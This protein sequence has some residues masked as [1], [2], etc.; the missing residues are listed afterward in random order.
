M[1]PALP[2]LSGREVV[3]VFETLGWLVARQS[4]S[5]IVMVKEG[6]MGTLSIPDH[7]EVAKGTLRSLIRA[8]GLTVAEFVAAV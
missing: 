6:E 4:G 5:H 2:V 8:G 7:R 1:P 3:R